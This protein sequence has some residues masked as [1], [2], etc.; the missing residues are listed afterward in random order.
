MGSSGQGVSLCP[1]EREPRG[2]ADRSPG[3][4][5][6]YIRI[7][8]Q[9]KGSWA[10]TD[11]PSGSALSLEEAWA[12][13]RASSTFPAVAWGMV[14]AL[15]LRRPPGGARAVRPRVAGLRNRRVAYWN[16]ALMRPHDSPSTDTG[17][18]TWIVALRM[19]PLTEQPA[20]RWYT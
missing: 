10:G 3:R 5:C 9:L 8:D 13:R 20:S 17:Q 14:V 7:P 12:R 6:S 1:G 18:S 11:A 15:G 19:R 16:S 4:T 2:T